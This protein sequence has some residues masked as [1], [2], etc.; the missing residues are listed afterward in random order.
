MND[1]E[2][3][4][5]LF[6]ADEDNLVFDNIKCSDDFSE[7]KRNELKMLSFKFLGPV[8]LTAASGIGN[9]WKIESIEASLS[10]RYSKAIEADVIQSFFTLNS[11]MDTLEGSTNLFALI[12]TP[13]TED[14]KLIYDEISEYVHPSIMQGKVV[15]ENLLGS[16]FN[17]SRFI[18]AELYRGIN[19]IEYS[20]GSSRKLYWEEGQ[21]YYCVGLIERRNSKD[22]RDSNLY[23][24]DKNDPLRKR[25]L[26]YIPSYYVMSILPDYYEHLISETLELYNKKGVYPCIRSIKLSYKDKKVVYLEEFTLENDIIKS[27][28]VVLVHQNENTE[29]NKNLS[30]F[31]KKLRLILDRKKDLKETLRLVNPYFKEERWGTILDED[32]NRI[33]EVLD[34]D[35]D[36]EF[37]V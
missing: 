12:S 37:E 36:F 21:R 29:M 28:G 30:Y 33:G 15:N 13:F 2:I 3:I 1:E 4:L 24:F 32:L 10:L 7:E 9:N 34:N 35:S 26:D 6:Y 19:L 8:F 11:S 27:F 25:Y 20:L 18:K 17:F 14:I 31:R 16:R 5:G 23:T 22:I